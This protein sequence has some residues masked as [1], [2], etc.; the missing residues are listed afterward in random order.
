MKAILGSLDQKATRQRLLKATE[1]S[2][3]SE[4]EFEAALERLQQTTV[5]PPTVDIA[6]TTRVESV[7]TSGAS[8]A[9]AFDPHAVGAELVEQFKVAEG[10]AWTGADFQ[11]RFGLSA[12]VLHRRRKEHRILYWRDAR[13]EFHYPKWQFTATGAL[14]P[15]VQEVLQIFRSVDEWR[16]MAYFL[17]PRRQLDDRRPLDLLRGG[18]KDKVLAHATLHAKENTW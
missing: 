5:E 18:E 14:L 3:Y 1:Q 13:H 16:L 7:E 15:G 12:A 17:N 6:D 11:G 2:G 10:G 9:N 4:A 8:D